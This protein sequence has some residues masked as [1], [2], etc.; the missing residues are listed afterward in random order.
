MAITAA[1]VIVPIGI[2]FFVSGLIVNL[3]QLYDACY[4][5]NKCLESENIVCLDRRIAIDS[6][7]GLQKA[8]VDNDNYGRDPNWWRIARLQLPILLRMRVV[9][10]LNVHQRPRKHKPLEIDQMMF[11]GAGSYGDLLMLLNVTLN[12]KV[13][14]T[15]YG[16]LKPPLG[17][18]RLKI[19]LDPKARNDTEYKLETFSGVYRKLSGKDV[20]FEYPMTEA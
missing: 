11:T 2:L 3:I 5:Y 18:H 9:L 6:V 13:L 16:Q 10:L 7:D 14:P 1:L 17:K 4:D 20:V 12:E 8:Q 19:Y 15:T